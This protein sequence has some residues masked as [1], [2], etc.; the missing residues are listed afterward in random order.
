MSE[1][2][3]DPTRKRVL[4]FRSALLPISETFIREQAEAL[5][6]YE[7]IY[8]GLT[9]VSSG[10]P[11]EARTVL[12]TRASG[13]RAQVAKLLYQVFG[14][15]PSFKAEAKEIKPALIHAHFA[16]DGAAALPLARALGV[17]LVVTL[18]GYDVTTR[19]K[20]QRASSAGRLY[21]AKKQRLC[22]EATRF[23]CVSEFIR[24]K[25]IAAGFPEEKLVMHYTGVNVET[26]RP[27]TLERDGSVL[28]VGRLVEKKGC[29][30]LLDAMAEVCK[31]HPKTRLTII[32]DGPLKTE[33]QARAAALQVPVDFLGAQSPAQVRE[34]MARAS[35]FCVP[36][37]EAPNGDSE[38][39]GMVFGEAQA[40]G[41]PVVSFRHG[42]IPEAVADGETGILLG[43]RDTVGLVAAVA[44]L[45]DDRELWS[46][47]SKAGIIRINEQFSLARQTRL[48][49]E[50]YDSVI[51]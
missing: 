3:E 7:P 10:L 40:L 15:G 45:L 25:A 35:I 38:G 51:N 46:K 20:D 6:T 42:G 43:E 49:E 31:T 41:T 24:G 8:T 27:S 5:E 28:F 16:W 29:R 23:I 12:L 2:P 30:Y 44:S 37:V 13:K 1:R 4:I 14:Y 18:H 34:R 33:L 21:L 17:P 50:I 11:A 36:S 9:R 22:D 32:G 48:L 47:Y 26:F 19:E 39:F